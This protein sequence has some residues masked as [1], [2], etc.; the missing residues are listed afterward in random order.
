MT[1]EKHDRQ[2][3]AAVQ[4]FV[5]KFQSV[6]IGHTHVENHAA[7]G[8]NIVIF[9][10]GSGALISHGFDSCHA[11]RKDGGIA[12]RFFVVNDASQR[13]QSSAAQFFGHAVCSS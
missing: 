5:L 7:G 9:Q 1:G 6:H 2:I 8:T 13:P 4:H 3:N 12:H 11:K 10:K